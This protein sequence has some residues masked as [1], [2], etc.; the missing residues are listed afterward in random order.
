M[1]LQDQQYYWIEFAGKK[2]EPALYVEMYQGFY[3]CGDYE[4]YPK[5]DVTVLKK[6]EYLNGVKP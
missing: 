6:C 3:R 5:S 2:V 1:Q 4:N